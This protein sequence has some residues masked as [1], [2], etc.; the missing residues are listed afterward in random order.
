MLHNL[1]KIK[2]EIIYQYMIIDILKYYIFSNLSH[3]IYLNLGI[4]A[5]KHIDK[6]AQRFQ[7]L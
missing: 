2:V 6:L 7:V 1:L 3:V 5:T 4:I